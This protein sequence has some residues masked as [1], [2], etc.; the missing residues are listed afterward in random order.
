MTG[1]AFEVDEHA[2]SLLRAE[3]SVAVGAL[4]LRHAGEEQVSAELCGDARAWA[5]E[6]VGERTVCGVAL[7]LDGKVS[8]PRCSGC[9][10]VR[11]AG[12]RLTGSSHADE[13][14]SGRDGGLGLVLAQ[15]EAFARGEHDSPGL[16]VGASSFDARHER[17][18]MT[19]GACAVRLKEPARFH[20]S[21]AEGG[22]M[23]RGPMTK[24]LEYTLKSHRHL[25]GARVLYCAKAF[26]ADSSKD[27]PR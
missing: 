18:H 17:H 26:P 22:H 2:P 9:V 14:A 21:P 1:R 12:G 15:L 23:R 16:C 19:G 27:L 5:V 3:E 24:K 8:R 10:E 11:D 13:A 20:T 4:V 6:C 25:V 7:V